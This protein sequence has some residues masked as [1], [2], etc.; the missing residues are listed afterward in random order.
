M[1]A[2]LLL[3]AGACSG[4]QTKE[5]EPVPEE[6][7]PEEPAPP[8]N[9]PFLNLLE[10]FEAAYVELACRANKDYDPTNS[11]GMVIEPYAEMERFVG[12]KS[13]SLEAYERVLAKHGFS[14]ATEYFKGREK[15]DIARPNWFA[16]LS[17]RL[18]DIV[19][20]CEK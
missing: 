20:A 17:G 4:A 9:D 14:A 13:T 12:E 16:N 2:L 10:R 8:S 5:A 1:M 7:K 11:I 3:L 18:I 19:E 6:P 15:I